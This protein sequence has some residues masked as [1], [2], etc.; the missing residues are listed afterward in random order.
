MNSTTKKF[1]S[2]ILTTAIVF[3]QAGATVSA[4]TSSTWGTSTSQTTQ[5]SSTKSTSKNY[6]NSSD[7]TDTDKY[8]NAFPYTYYFKVAQNK[9]YKTLY[10]YIADAL[11]DRKASLKFKGYAKKYSTDVFWDVNEDLRNNCP[12]LYYVTGCTAK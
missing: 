5:S 9:S 8:G 11:R 12:D 2:A 1:L 3:T 4:A 7:Y 6:N 10:K